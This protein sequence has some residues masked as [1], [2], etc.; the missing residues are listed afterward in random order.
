M[1]NFE[2]TIA[3][4]SKIIAMDEKTDRQLLADAKA[5]LAFIKHW[6]ANEKR[7]K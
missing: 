2:K 7:A 5:A 3:K 6:N 4:A 1:S